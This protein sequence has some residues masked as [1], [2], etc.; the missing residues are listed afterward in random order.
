MMRYEAI[1]VL[2]TMPTMLLAAGE[3]AE[4]DGGAPPGE[5]AVAPGQHGE[6][7]GVEVETL[8][9][10]HPA[11]ALETRLALLG[12]EA[13]EDAAVRPQVGEREQHVLGRP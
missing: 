4:G 1:I 10:E 7:H 5:P 2:L 6:G 13:D 9:G 3:V 8:L 12:P 11:L